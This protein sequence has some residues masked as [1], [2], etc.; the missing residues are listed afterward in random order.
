MV[1]VSRTAARKSRRLRIRLHFRSDAVDGEAE[2]SIRRFSD[3]AQASV[4]LVV[5]DDSDVR[6][7]LAANGETGRPLRVCPDMVQATVLVVEDD[8]DVRELLAMGIRRGGMNVAVASSAD[9]ALS[10]AQEVRPDVMIIDI[11]L[12]GVDGLELIRCLR[13]VHSLAAIP[14]IVLT[15]QDPF[16]VGVRAVGLGITAFRQKPISQ[17]DLIAVITE[18]L[19][20]GWDS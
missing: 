5:E 14:T 15:G 18:C 10:L 13:A 6:E 7:F 17:R 1:D 8:T 16:D 9:R 11:G 2:W 20:T 3:M 4:L 12:P 19:P